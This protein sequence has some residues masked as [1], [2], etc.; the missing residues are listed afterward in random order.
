MKQ[1][2]IVSPALNA[3]WNDFLMEREAN[4]IRGYKRSNLPDLTDVLTW[5]ESK[6]SSSEEFLAILTNV[7]N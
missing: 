2:L 5:M 4:W 1:P 3:D 6:A 7:A